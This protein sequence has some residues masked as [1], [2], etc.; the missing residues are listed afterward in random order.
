M[1]CWPSEKNNVLRRHS[2]LAYLARRHCRRNRS[3]CGRLHV[4]LHA[5]Q[6][7]GRHSLAAGTRAPALEV[8]MKRK[9]I[10]QQAWAAVSK[11]SRK[12]LRDLAGQYAIYTHHATADLDTPAYGEVRRVTI[13]VGDK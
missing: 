2:Y 1:P 12:P 13:I 9:P 7:E 11:K 6:V 5:P 4:A 10:R 3:D 8:R